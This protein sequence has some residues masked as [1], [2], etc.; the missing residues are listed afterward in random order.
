[1]MSRQITPT[2]TNADGVKARRT[3][4]GPS[5]AERRASASANAAKLSQYSTAMKRNMLGAPGASGSITAHSA[6]ISGDCQSPAGG[7]AM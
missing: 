2:K 6:V 7:L 1:M 4:T 5:Q 3:V